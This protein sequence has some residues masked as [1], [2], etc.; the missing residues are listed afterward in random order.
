MPFVRPQKFPNART[1]RRS[2]GGIQPSGD[3]VYDERK[4]FERKVRCVS[5]VPRFTAHRPASPVKELFGG[6][7]VSDLVTHVDFGH[8]RGDEYTVHANDPET[9]SRPQ[10]TRR[11]VEPDGSIA[12]RR[13][14]SLNGIGDYRH[15]PHS[16]GK[17]D[18]EA[19]V[20]APMDATHERLHKLPDAE[21][22]PHRNFELGIV[23]RYG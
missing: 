2:T 1:R 13:G 7:E 22:I 3:V 20:R 15:Q 12:L 8:H 17:C 23:S 4:H 14:H 9:R 6:P 21:D 19:P 11:P 16:S 18:V 10:R 5:G